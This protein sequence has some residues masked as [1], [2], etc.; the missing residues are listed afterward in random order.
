[1]R[2]WKWVGLAGALGAV[3]VGGVV[4]QKRRHRT[5][6]DYPPEELRSKLHERLAALTTPG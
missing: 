6:V 4:L 1:V 3:A 5:W 2:W